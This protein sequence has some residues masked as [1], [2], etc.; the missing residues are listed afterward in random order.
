MM[1]HVDAEGYPRKI[2]GAATY[3]CFLCENQ[4]SHWSDVGYV[5]Y[6]GCGFSPRT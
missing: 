3:M 2:G 1:T 5:G 6:V 4:W